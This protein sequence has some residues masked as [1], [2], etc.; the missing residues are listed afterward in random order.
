MIVYFSG[1]G[2]SR[3]CAQF[4]ADRLCDEA[5]DVLTLLQSKEPTHLY[6]ETPW[7]FVCPTYAWQLPHIFK[8]FFE[9]S[10]FE[11]SPDI[12]FVMTCGTGIGNADRWNRELSKAKGF[13]YR[14]T[15][16]VVM[17]ENYIALFN[18][19]ETPEATQI[20]QNAL[21]VLEH[22]A[23]Q[24][25]RRL[26]FPFIAP[27]LLDRLYSGIVNEAF[28]K[29]I[30]KSKRFT[31]SNDCIECGR[32]AAVCPTNNIRFEDGKPVW[33]SDCTHC[34]ACICGCPASAIEYGKA[35]VGKSRYQCPSYPLKAPKTNDAKKVQ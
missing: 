23:T 10:T 28:Y 30:V 20:I 31:V 14:G 29:L 3:F 8:D 4:L 22:G 26:S 11:G 35:S 5:L 2:N 6:S 25:R 34:M 21:P 9:K 1:T 33:G 19:P 16:E 32:C 17:P 18:A 7:V 15:L 12:Y 27:S 13:I 24:I